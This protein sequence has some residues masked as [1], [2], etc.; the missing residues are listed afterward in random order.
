MKLIHIK[1]WTQATHSVAALKYSPTT[2]NLSFPQAS[3]V[4]LTH[5]LCSE[6]L[7]SFQLPLRLFCFVLAFCLFIC[8]SCWEDH[9]HIKQSAFPQSRDITFQGIHGCLKLCRYLLLMSNKTPV[10][11]TWYMVKPFCPYEFLMASIWQVIWFSF[12]FLLSLPAPFLTP[13]FPSFTSS[14]WILWK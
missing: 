11:W 5:K 9:K 10:C 3:L 1:W 7:N 14:F 12:A 13:L 4:P 6:F 2:T 8:L